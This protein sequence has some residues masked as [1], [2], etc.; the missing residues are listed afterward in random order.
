MCFIGTHTDSCLNSFLSTLY[1]HHQQR[2]QQ[3][4]ETKQQLQF[5]IQKTLWTRKGCR[6]VVVDAVDLIF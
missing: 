5:H 2:Q 1:H 3:W 4:L 6:I